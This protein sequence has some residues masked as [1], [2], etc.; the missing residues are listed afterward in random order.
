MLDPIAIALWP[1]RVVSLLESNC[2]DKT[3][4]CCW[5]ILATWCYPTIPYHP[6]HSTLTCSLAS[7]ETLFSTRRHCRPANRSWRP[8]R[9][10][11]ESQYD[12]GVWA[13]LLLV[14][15]SLAQRKIQESNSELPMCRGP[16]DTPPEARIVLLPPWHTPLVRVYRPE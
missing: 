6:S 14:L 7:P 12:L 1:R 16:T 11:L 8:Q 2:R 10:L 3:F 13:L 5:P 15:L 4:P 9:Y